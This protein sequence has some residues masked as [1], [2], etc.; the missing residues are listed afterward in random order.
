VYHS[1]QMSHAA[2]GVGRRSLGS[3]CYTPVHAWQAVVCTTRTH[4][5]QPDR[6]R[7]CRLIAPCVAL[8][9]VNLVIPN[10]GRRAAA[11]GEHVVTTAVL[12]TALA[13]AVVVPNVEVR[14]LFLLLS[15]ARFSLYRH[16]L[17]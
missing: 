11:F 1:R 8:Q 9:V 10:M 13:L 16:A 6:S 17:R 3:S 14:R 2:H 12:S 5:Q 15:L 4:Q 7:C